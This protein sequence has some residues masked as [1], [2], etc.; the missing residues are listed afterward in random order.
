[1]L[2][3]GHQYQC[4]FNLPLKGHHYAIGSLKGHHYAIGSLKGTQ[5]FVHL[6][7]QHQFEANIYSLLLF[8]KLSFLSENF[9]ELCNTRSWRGTVQEGTIPTWLE[10]VFVTTFFRVEV[11][12]ILVWKIFRNHKNLD[13]WKEGSEK[14][15][16]EKLNITFLLRDKHYIQALSADTFHKF[17]ELSRSAILN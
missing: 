4:L 1:M 16:E 7:R 2:V 12:Q 17:I 6:S 10:V 14:N 3:A 9:R 5:C 15:H 8:K 11:S 13:W